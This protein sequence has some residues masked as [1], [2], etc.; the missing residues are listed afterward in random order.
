MSPIELLEQRAERGTPRGASEIWAGTQ[1][2]LRSEQ[3]SDSRAS[4]T[5]LRVALALSAAALV[6]FAGLAT[7]RFGTEVE[8]I[9]PATTDESTT[10]TESVGEPAP[11]LIEGMELVGVGEPWSPAERDGRIFTTGASPTIPSTRVYAMTSNPFA[12]PVVG[13]D[14]LEGGGFSPWSMNLT[15][16]ELSEATASVERAGD[17]WRL[18]HGGEL[19]EV[20]RFAEDSAYFLMENWQF[21]FRN[22]SAGATLQAQPAESPWVWIARLLRNAEPGDQSTSRVPL[23]LAWR[24]ATNRKSDSRFTYFNEASVTVSPGWSRNATGSSIGWR[25]LCG[26]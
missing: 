12:G 13:I 1:N 25:T 14:S 9:T 19:V 18:P 7:D 16:A 17:S 24:P 10:P 23:S 4:T 3:P 20:A 2:A 11:I 8:T 6:V 15:A 21:D 26:P 22:G 5:G